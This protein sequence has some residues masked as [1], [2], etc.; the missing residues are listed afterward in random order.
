MAAVLVVL[1]MV[2]TFLTGM[3]LVRE[4]NN[5]K[6]TMELREVCAQIDHDNDVLHHEVRAYLFG[7]GDGDDA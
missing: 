5:R 4:G 1:V 2:D 7:G 6:A 3:L